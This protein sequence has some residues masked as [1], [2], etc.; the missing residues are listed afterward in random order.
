MQRV[1]LF[2]LV[3]LLALL[4]ISIPLYSQNLTKKSD[5]LGPLETVWE[6]CDANGNMPDWFSK[7][8][9]TERGL[10]CGFIDG[11]NRLFVVSNSSGVPVVKILDAYTGED[12]GELSTVGIAGGDIPLN[13]IEVDNWFGRIYACNLT[14]DA[15]IEPFKIYVWDD[16][17]A[18]PVLVIEENQQPIRLGDRI[19]ITKT[20]KG[21]FSRNILVAG[22]NSNILLEYT[23]YDGISFTQ[24]VITLDGGPLGENPCA[25]YVND[26]D[27]VVNSN[28]NPAKYFTHAGDSVYSFPDSIVAINSNSFKT[29]W[30]G[31]SLCCDFPMI[32]SFQY[33]DS[34]NARLAYTGGVYDTTDF[35]YTIKDET[36]SLGD[37]PNIEGYGDLDYNFLGPVRDTLY[38][39][40][41]SANNGVACYWWI[42][43]ASPVEL[44]YFT[45]SV[46]NGSVNLKW[47]TATETNN[48]G[49]ELQRS[50]ING[51]PSVWEAIGFVEGK[52]TTTEIQNYEFTDSPPEA[53][54]YKYRLKQIDF[55]GTFEFSEEITVEV[56]LPKTFRLGQ[57]YPNPFY[58]GTRGNPNT[59]ISYSI[60]E[61]SNVLLEVFDINGRIVK[62]LVDEK[63]SPGSYQ[64]SF[65]GGN[66]SSG[67]YF[68]RLK[69]N[70]YSE[71]KKMLLLR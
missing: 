24:N 5:W 6:R 30:D 68:Y 71:T 28:G 69:T 3:F 4:G 54:K 32:C 64:V 48:K 67:V 51:K 52:G 23:S 40:V 50:F 39:Y 61:K 17:S 18:D 38:V 37:S 36:P 45:A 43:A 53:G 62:T 1:N 57:N 49:F 44:N 33:G 2:L 58:K 9:N 41:L 26:F 8:E 25:D 22:A 70:K 66:I 11:V 12:I 42:G 55:E 29:Y 7:T 63:Q 21:Y 27:F 10:A 13:D 20:V 19:S 47:Q 59:I 15:S 16:L 35:D 14:N 46:Y 65:I 31:Q 34:V 56:G 60:A